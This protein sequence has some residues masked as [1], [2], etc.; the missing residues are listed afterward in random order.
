MTNVNNQTKQTCE[1]LKT[2]WNLTHTSPI[3]MSLSKFA[4]EHK[5]R[6]GPAMVLMLVRKGIITKTGPKA[7]PSYQWTSTT[8]PCVTMANALLQEC[9]NY[10]LEHTTSDKVKK[11]TMRENRA[12]RK[13]L[14]IC[15]RIEELEGFVND[16]LLKIAIKQKRQSNYIFNIKR[17]GN[18][19]LVW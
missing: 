4:R 16:K 8:E 6:Y 17:E 2:L 14:L 5:L 7:A 12:K 10:T 19:I 11:Q 9:I 18:Y 15:G 3:Q 13:T 1:F